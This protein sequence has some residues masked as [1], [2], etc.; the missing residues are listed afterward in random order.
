M[1]CRSLKM[2][3]VNWQY[4]EGVKK[5]TSLTYLH[6]FIASLHQLSLGYLETVYIWLHDVPRKENMQP[7]WSKIWI[8]G[9][10]HLVFLFL[11]SPFFSIGAFQGFLTWTELCWSH[12]VWISGCNTENWSHGWTFVRSS[13]RKKCVPTWQPLNWM[14]AKRKHLGNF[15]RWYLVNWVDLVVFWG[16]MMSVHQWCWLMELSLEASLKNPFPV[17]SEQLTAHSEAWKNGPHCC[18]IVL[19]MSI[20]AAQGTAL[21][22]KHDKMRFQMGEFANISCNNPPPKKKRFQ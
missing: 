18:V 11:P 4:V 12:R 16:P 2:Y 6:C 7:P 8:K 10:G 9:V 22:E 20:N 1:A 21:F 3:D 13:T 19:W 17:L 5:K 15:W 14:P